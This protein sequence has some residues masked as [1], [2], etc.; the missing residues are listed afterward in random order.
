MAAGASEARVPGPVPSG[1]PASGRAD[2]P[3]D[4]EFDFARPFQI[5]LGRAAVIAEVLRECGY[6]PCTADTVTA[7][8]AKPG[9]QHTVIGQF[10]A[11]ALAQGRL[12]ALSVTPPA[13]YPG[14]AGRAN[15]T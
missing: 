6:A 12:A 13:C 4:R 5:D 9:D 11:S 2:D 1:H 14:F 3:A 8:L 15:S 10:A 7:E